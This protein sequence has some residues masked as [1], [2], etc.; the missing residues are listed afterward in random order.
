MT[1]ATATM[2]YDRLREACR[3]ILEAH[4]EA[5]REYRQ[6]ERNDADFCL[7]RKMEG[8]ALVAC[9]DAINDI[10]RLIAYDDAFRLIAYVGPFAAHRLLRDNGLDRLLRRYG[11]FGAQDGGAE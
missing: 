3:P 5:K 9:D 1:I 4:R 11:S 2:R 10:H 7:S 6:G 8:I